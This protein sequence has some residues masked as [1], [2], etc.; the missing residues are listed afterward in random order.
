[1][2]DINLYHNVTII[3]AIKQTAYQAF[4]VEL[5]HGRFKIRIRSIETSLFIGMLAKSLEVDFGIF[6]KYLINTGYFCSRLKYD[7]NPT[8]LYI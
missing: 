6:Y 7:L 8:A 4:A 1:M 3:H 5:L 2:V